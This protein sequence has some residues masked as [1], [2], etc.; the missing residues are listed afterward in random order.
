MELGYASTSITRDIDFVSFRGDAQFEALVA[1]IEE[2]ALTD[3][4]EAAMLAPDSWD[5]LS[6]LGK[7]LLTLGRYEESVIHH[8]RACDLA[9]MQHV[10]AASSL[11][12]HLAGQAAEARTAAELASNMKDSSLGSYNLA[13][14][15]ALAGNRDEALD[16]L[17]SSLRLGNHDA[18]IAHDPDLRSLHG[19]PEFEVIVA[20]VKKRIGE[21]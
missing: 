15:Y 9:R 14:Y 7:A 1:E 18:W 3:A 11:A 13:C 8:A 17:R 5:V 12:L 6:R 2:R 19:D 10:C 21:E 16:H 20:E 4:R